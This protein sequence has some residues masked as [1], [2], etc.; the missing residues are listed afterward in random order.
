AAVEVPVIAGPHPVPAHQLQNLRTHIP[1]VPGRIVQ[2]AQLGPLPCR[3]QRSL[4]PAELPAENL[5]IVLSAALLLIKPAPGAADG[6]P[7]VK[8]TIIIEYIQVFKPIFLTKPVK[9]RS[10]GPP[11]IV[12][13][14]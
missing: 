3:L 2:K 1:P 10:S 13:S 8:V 4:Q 14:L 9:F 6:I 12:I 7:V 11:V 5:F